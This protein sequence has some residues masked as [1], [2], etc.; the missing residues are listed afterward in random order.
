MTE[1]NML[2]TGI[3]GGSFNPIHY[4][5]IRLAQSLCS[6]G[7]VGELW[8]MVSP[9]NPLK[10]N[11]P[12]ATAPAGLNTVSRLP[13]G[14]ADMNN[15]ALLADEARLRLA[16]LA[17][18]GL[19]GRIRVSDF[20][21]RLPR[22]SYMALTLQA[23]RLTFPE[24]EFVLVVGADNWQRFSQWYRADEIIARHSVI[25]FPR[26]GA[27][28]SPRSLPPGVT[29]APTPLIDISATSIRQRIAAHAFDGS[30]LPPPVWHEIQKQGY[31]Q[32]DCVS[33][34]PTG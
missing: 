34:S 32:S 4:G 33:S 15:Q 19:D 11:G 2:L 21:M 29:L 3:Y 13:F 7:L 1:A 14:L 10:Q 25:V 28:V 26:R 6:L 20:E 30:T 16:R 24:R 5:H 9:L 22:P 23:L 12:T 31:Y 27:A 8:L 17:V 18:Q